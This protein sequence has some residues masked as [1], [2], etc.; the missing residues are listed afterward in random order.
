VLGFLDHEALT[1]R[2]CGGYLPE[3]TDPENRFVTDL[4]HQCYRCTAVHARQDE[5]KDSKHSR[6][7]VTWPVHKKEK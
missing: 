5:Y 6:A 4:P 3:T 7:L 1:C 2:G